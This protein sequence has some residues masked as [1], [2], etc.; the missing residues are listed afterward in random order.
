MIDITIRH[1]YAGRVRFKI[2]I[3]KKYHGISYWLSHSLLAIQGIKNI[4]INEH[5][6]SIVVNYDPL[7]INPELIEKRLRS[8]DFKKGDLTETEHQ[9]T[10]GDIAMDIIGALSVALLPN[11]WGALITT[12]LIAPTLIAGASELKDKRVSSE[13]LDALAIG[14]SA[15]RG[16]Y[17]TAMLTKSLLSLGEYMEQVT[18]RN[19]DQLLA[20]LM[21][22]K[23]SLV[24][25]VS[26]QDRQ[27]ISSAL[28][29]KG[30]LIELSPGVSI[31]IDGH[32]EAGIAFINQSTLTGENVPVRRE[33]GALVYS[34][35]SVHDGTIKVR[36]DKIGSE[37]TTAQ[38]AKLIYDSLSE[39]SEIQQVTQDMADRRVKITLGIGIAVYALTQDINR[40]ASVFMVDYS[41][42]L[43]LSTPVAFKSIMYRAAQEGILF[44]GGSTIEKLVGIDTCVFDKTGTLTYG[45]M[46]VTDV[47]PLSHNNSPQELLAIAASV[48]EHSNH[49]LSQS[50]VN[51]AKN[52]QLPHIDHGE[53]E[54]VIAHGLRSTL[55]GSCLV[56]GSRHF[57]EVHEK[58]DFIPFEEKISEY[59][60]L[61]RH[62]IFISRHHRLIGMIGLR[63]ELREDVHQTLLSL[64]ESGIKELMMI[65]GDRHYKAK[66]L[67]DELLLDQVFSEATPESK[68]NIVEQLQSQGKKV[69][70]IGDGV[71]DAP[72]LSKADVGVAMGCGTELA[73]Q[74]ADVVLLHD[75]LSSVAN[76]RQ[77]ALVAMSLVNSNI[78]LAEYIN[79]GIMM[80]AAMGILS[81][82]VSSLLHNGTTLAILG[83]SVAVKKK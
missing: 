43:K 8:L 18:C 77:L 5:A 24:W 81:P 38:I 25:R 1:H 4:R 54:Y 10:R 68:S 40:V 60:K 39:K 34:G 80:G 28:I 78:K 33:K 7:I 50:V 63:D 55:N 16:D 12:T 3:L 21:Q 56:M 47:V 37:S 41:C 74:V 75:K 20:D 35:T 29:K 83:R 59:E 45:D 64:R 82:A 19:S 14:L 70:F 57:L 66:M 65:S 32:I 61:G 72:A 13:V 58:V 30:D 51:A 44:K 36:V 2:A 11:R 9:Y 53:V 23:E 62:L 48:E 67:G 22:P 71:N 79:S 69:M 15:W 27:Q 49:P 26:G 6:C 46:E 17:G 42:A 31:P 52:H 73:R 76:A